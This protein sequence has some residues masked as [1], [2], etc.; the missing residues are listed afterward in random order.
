[1]YDLEFK[2]GESD[3]EDYLEPDALREQYTELLAE[4]PNLVSVEDPFD[5]EDWDGWAALATEQPQ[6]QLVA[7]ELTASSAE[8][9]EEA[10]EKQAANCLLVKLAQA[11]TVTEALD[12]VK[13]AK[14]AG[15]GCVVSAG[16]W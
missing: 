4:L 11:G 13:A 15:W 14:A 10:V 12:C 6:L 7:D 1:M 5:Q 8:R 9:V 16:I 2:T 3:P